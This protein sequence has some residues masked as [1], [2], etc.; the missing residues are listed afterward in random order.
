MKSLLTLV[1]AFHL[2]SASLH[3]ASSDTP[4]PKGALNIFGSVPEATS[5]NARANAA[6]LLGR[7]L[8]TEG[9][10]HLCQQTA[11]FSNTWMEIKGLKITRITPGS[12]T[13]ADEANGIL[14]WALVGLSADTHRTSKPGAPKWSAWNNGMPL[15]FPAAIQVVR[16]ADGQWVASA[17]GLDYF[18]PIGDPSSTVAL[19]NAS[20]PP[21][22]NGA[23]GG[24][25]AA[26]AAQITTPLIKMVT[27]GFV[28]VVGMSLFSLFLKAAQP[29]RR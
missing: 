19:A 27:W 5:K 28:I 8:K 26:M 13:K 21:S 7:Y 3:G 1:S 2:L 9:D 12:V 29:K 23:T 25:G 4:A 22:K 15:L 11:A 16:R 20:I 17:P 24:A 18:S 14:E 6:A 10:G